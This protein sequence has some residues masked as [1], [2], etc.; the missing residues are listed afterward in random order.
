MA[1]WDMLHWIMTSLFLMLATAVI[2]CWRYVSQRKEREVAADREDR[3][4]QQAR[5]QRI[6]A[7]YEAW[8]KAKL[9]VVKPSEKE[10]NDGTLLTGNG[11][12][13][14][15]WWEASA[16]LDE[17]NASVAERRYA[18]AVR[19]YRK[20]LSILQDDAGLKEKLKEGLQWAKL[21]LAAENRKLNAATGS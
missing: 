4:R 16:K 7:N 19:S 2:V 10:K 17:G 12:G 9:P 18:D 6:E 21:R 1:D 20:G 3:A 11:A 5:L 14:D 8:T 13:S 15:E